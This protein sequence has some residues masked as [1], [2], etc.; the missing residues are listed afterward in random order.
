MASIKVC[1][2]KYL[3]PQPSDVQYT[4]VFEKI[5]RGRVFDLKT[6]FITSGKTLIRSL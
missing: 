5:M 4:D 6:K 2:V 1:S 3:P